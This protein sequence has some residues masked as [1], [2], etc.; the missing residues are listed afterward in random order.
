MFLTYGSM[1]ADSGCCPIFGVREDSGSA[2]I[3]CGETETSVEEHD[4]LLHTKSSSLVIKRM[5]PQFYRH[6]LT[7]IFPPEVGSTVREAGARHTP[8]FEISEFA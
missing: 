7:V 6:R 2:I 1:G 3:D 8:Y 5:M 4:R